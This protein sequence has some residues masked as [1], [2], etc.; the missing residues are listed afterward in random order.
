[1]AAV[2]GKFTKMPL[3][4]I[5]IALSPSIPENQVAKIERY[6]MLL[7]AKITSVIR[8]TTTTCL[9]TKRVGD[10]QYQEAMDWKIPVVKTRWIEECHNK[11]ALVRW[12]DFLVPCFYGF[13]VSCTG[14]PPEE[15]RMISEMV[16]QHGGSFS[17]KLVKHEVTHLVAKMCEGDK[18]NH[19]KGWKTVFIVGKKWVEDCVR[20]KSKLSST[21]YYYYYY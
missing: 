18:Y 19:A 5:E 16:E 10:S 12:D 7:G 13:T 17:E 14:Y 15:R 11:R 4:G 2:P 3:S 21:I 8:K 9:L 1:M 20:D 6:A